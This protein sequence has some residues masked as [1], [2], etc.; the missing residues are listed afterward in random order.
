M[1]GFVGFVLGAASVLV[2]QRWAGPEVG[3]YTPMLGNYASMTKESARAAAVRYLDSLSDY[4]RPDSVN[5]QGIED[6]RHHHPSEE[7]SSRLVSL[8]K[9]PVKHGYE[10]YDRPS[11]E[12][13]G[14]VRQ[15]ELHSF[16]FG[17]G[18]ELDK[19]DGNPFYYQVV[20][21]EP[22]TGNQSRIVAPG[23]HEIEEGDTTLSV[24][25]AG[26]LTFKEI[27]DCYLY[28]HPDEITAQP[29]SVEADGIILPK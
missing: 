1:R 23:T 4:L 16:A 18:K 25:S 27:L 7:P 12:V 26:N 2:W 3:E 8:Q 13:R 9:K 6:G 24:T 29:G 21:F 22:K 5:V 15:V 10:L 17:T 11:A 28:N 19:D 14:R 20:L